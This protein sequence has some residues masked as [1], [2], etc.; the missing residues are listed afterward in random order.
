MATKKLTTAVAT[1]NGHSTVSQCS[2]HI[3]YQHLV[4][5]TYIGG[6]V[7]NNRDVYCLKTSSCMTLCLPSAVQAM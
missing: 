3:N 6:H 7:S 5:S 4:Y 2:M 1:R